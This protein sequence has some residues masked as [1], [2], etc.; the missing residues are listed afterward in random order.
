VY[1]QSV[2][3]HPIDRTAFGVSDLRAQSTHRQA[4]G[5]VSSSIVDHADAI[6]DPNPVDFLDAKLATNEEPG[7]DQ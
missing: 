1:D 2:F 5:D 4:A 6:N 3:F 7:V